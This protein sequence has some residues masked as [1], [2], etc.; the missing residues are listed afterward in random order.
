MSDIA[1]TLTTSR[2]SRARRILTAGRPLV[3]PV[4]PRPT[5]PLP[6][7]RTLLQLRRNAIGTWGD[8]AYEL[9]IL[10]GTFLGRTSLILNAPD[11]IRRVLIDN[12]ANYGRTP[13][14][15]RILHPTHRRRSLPGRGQCL[16]APAAARGAGLRPAQPRDRGPARRRRGRGDGG[17]P[18]CAGRPAR[19]IVL[20]DHAAPGARGRRPVPLLAGDARARGRHPRR[21]RALRHPPGPA[22][23][24]RFPAPARGAR[25]ARPG[26][27]AAPGATS[28]ACS[29]ASSPS[30][31]ARRR[32]TRRATCST[33]WSPPATR[34]PA[35]RSRPTQLRD[36]IATLTDRRP[37]DHGADHVLGRLPPVALAPRLAGA[38]GR[39]G[40][41]RRPLA[42]RRGPAVRAPAA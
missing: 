5:G 18:R 23:L 8:P 25:P 31:A 10:S 39:G 6:L 28:R 19:S 7:W 34:R 42:R 12:H 27:G 3:P 35:S 40:G 24:P 36:Q 15:L 13:A 29:T 16:E 14:T 11:A 30:A 4:P 20:R 33:C 2:A 22:V 32:P 26:R 17:R 21:H 41:R 38:R 1:A 37:R 9:P